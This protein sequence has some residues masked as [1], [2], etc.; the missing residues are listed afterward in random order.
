MKKPR[1]DVHPIN[2]SQRLI[3]YILYY[4]SPYGYHRQTAVLGSRGT[5]QSLRSQSKRHSRTIRSHQDDQHIPQAQQSH[6]E[7]LNERRQ[8]IHANS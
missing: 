3:V 6:E 7:I 2:G 5:L 1:L 4:L 8:G